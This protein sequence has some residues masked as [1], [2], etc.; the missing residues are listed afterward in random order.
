MQVP[1]ITPKPPVSILKEMLI[2]TNLFDLDRNLSNQITFH[3]KKQ[4]MNDR[5]EL[6]SLTVVRGRVSASLR[7]QL[8]WSQAGRENKVKLADGAVC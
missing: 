7:L 5:F 6:N 8:G 2:S 3:E 4:L 1:Q